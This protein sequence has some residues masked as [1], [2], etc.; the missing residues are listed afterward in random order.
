MH[1]TRPL[2]VVRIGEILR[3]DDRREVDVVPLP[4][5]RKTVVGIR[6][7][8]QIETLRHHAEHFPQ[9]GSDQRMIVHRQN[10]HGFGWVTTCRHDGGA[11]HP[12]AEGRLRKG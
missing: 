2:V 5:Q 1:A 7:F 8:D 4:E 11:A 12:E 6:G 9:R 3:H 10:H